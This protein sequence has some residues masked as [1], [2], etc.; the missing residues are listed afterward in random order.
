MNHFKTTTVSYNYFT[1]YLCI[2]INRVLE[3]MG[4]ISFFFNKKKVE[5]CY[6]FFFSSSL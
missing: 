6:L 3:N 1:V 4:K 5:L 2:S